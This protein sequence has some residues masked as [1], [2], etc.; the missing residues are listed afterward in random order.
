MGAGAGAAGG[1]PGGPGGCS[2]RPS[3]N[4]RV[5]VRRE[6]G[7]AGPAAALAR[8]SSITCPGRSPAPKRASAS[9]RSAGQA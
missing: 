8:S 4:Q 7:R 3:L 1:G 9:R 2:Q 6:G 5:M